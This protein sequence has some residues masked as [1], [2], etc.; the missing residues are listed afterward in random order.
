[1]LVKKLLTADLSKRYGNLKAGPDDIIKHKWFSGFDWDGLEK[2]RIRAPVPVRLPDG[3]GDASNYREVH[4]RRDG[5][6]CDVCAAPAPPSSP[7][8][9]SV[10]RVADYSFDD[11]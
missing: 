11:W 6:G 7:S 4:E 9:G 5:V 8:F 3:D 1:M 2:G 10:D